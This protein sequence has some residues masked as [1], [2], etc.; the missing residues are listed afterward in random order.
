MSDTEGIMIFVL[1]N[2]A[3]NKITVVYKEFSLFSFSN[4]KTIHVDVVSDMSTDYVKCKA[5]SPDHSDKAQ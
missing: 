1:T 3:L 2:K 4:N 5:S